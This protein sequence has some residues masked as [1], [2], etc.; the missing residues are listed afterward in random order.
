[1]N[2]RPLPR[3]L[4]LIV[5]T[6][7]PG[8]AARFLPL[9]LPPFVVKYAGSMLWAA[10]IYWLVSTVL[11]RTRLP[12]LFLISASLA[13]A[14]E[15]FKLYRS[16]QIDAFRST[17]PGILLLGKYFSAWDIAAYWI[18]ISIAAALDS[19]IRARPLPPTQ[20]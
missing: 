10:M 11:S 1:M 4:A 16:A 15:I 6:I 3:S 18:A 13:T 9:G 7:A 20:P 14:V 2:P 17:L 5:L 12:I 19:K 8:L